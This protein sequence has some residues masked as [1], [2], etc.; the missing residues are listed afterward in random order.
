MVGVQILAKQ[1]TNLF[2]SVSI[3]NSVITGLKDHKKQQVEE[4]NA[5]MDDL[6]NEADKSESVTDKKNIKEV[7]TETVDYT[8]VEEG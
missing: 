8:E 1:G 3:T 2:M 5:A 7:E 6:Y 4:E